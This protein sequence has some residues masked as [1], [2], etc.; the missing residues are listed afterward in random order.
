MHL[1]NWH[2]FFIAF[3][4][5]FVIFLFWGVVHFSIK[6]QKEWNA[7]KIAHNCEVIGKKKGQLQTTVMPISGGNGGTGVGMTVTPDTTGYLCDD[8]ITYW[9]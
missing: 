2:N 1:L 6:E 7:F 5:S 8:G 3:L 9:R 4:L